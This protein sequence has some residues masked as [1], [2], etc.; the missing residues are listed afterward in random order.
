[1]FH[2]AQSNRRPR[3]LSKA[4]LRVRKPLV[5]VGRSVTRRVSR[6]AQASENS[7]DALVK[8]RA[9]SGEMSILARMLGNSDGDMPTAVS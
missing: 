1:M 3:Y 6:A 9:E 8:L 7:F 2:E 4:S 5:S